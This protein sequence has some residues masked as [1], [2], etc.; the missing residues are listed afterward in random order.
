MLL[1]R[2]GTVNATKRRWPFLSMSHFASKLQ[3]ISVNRTLMR[4]FLGRLSWEHRDQKPVYCNI[5]SGHT[6]TTRDSLLF[7]GIVTLH[8]RLFKTLF[9]KSLME[10]GSFS[11]YNDEL[12]RVKGALGARAFSSL[13]LPDQG[14][15]SNGERSDF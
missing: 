1:R 2:P 10:I 12:C 11:K 14:P 8:A 6:E 3:K 15:R 9:S 7:G 4:S 13:C 5:K